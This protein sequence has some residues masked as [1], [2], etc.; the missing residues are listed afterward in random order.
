MTKTG[1]QKYGNL[2]LQVGGVSNLRQENARIALCV[3]F[4][5]SEFPAVASLRESA[6]WF[7][8]S[9]KFQGSISQ[10]SSSASLPP[11]SAS[12]F[13]LLLEPEDGVEMLLRNAALSPNYIH[14]T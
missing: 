3:Y 8:D 6:M 2:A 4:V 12:L 10:H 5:E 14:C 13:R 1:G 7:R 11:D 9:P